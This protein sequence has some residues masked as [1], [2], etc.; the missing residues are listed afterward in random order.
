[1]LDPD[2]PD[3]LEAF[4]AQWL[5]Q[6]PLTLARVAKI[7]PLITVDE[8][9]ELHDPGIADAAEL[10]RFIFDQRL[11]ILFGGGRQL[12]DLRIGEMLRQNDGQRR[13]ATLATTS[14]KAL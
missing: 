14:S 5:N 7:E 13:L 11:D 6:W 2:E 8:W 9:D 12:D 4:R 1:M 10:K 3:P